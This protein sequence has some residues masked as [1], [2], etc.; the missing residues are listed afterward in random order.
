MKLFNL[1]QDD[2][3][4]AEGV[5]FTDGRCALNWLNTNY[6]KI[7]GMAFFDCEEHIIEIHGH[8]RKIKI[9]YLDEDTPVSP[10]SEYDADENG[11]VVKHIRCLTS[12]P[13]KMCDSCTCW[14]STR[15][16]CS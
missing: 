16:Y 6:K 5:T 8:N 11:Y 1:I 15:K 9:K 2:I 4:L 7:T 13:D 10:T 3:I 14:K 12:D